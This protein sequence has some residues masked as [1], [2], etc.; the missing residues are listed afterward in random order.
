MK[1]HATLT[2]SLL[3][4]LTLAACGGGGGSDLATPSTTTN[5]T[6]PTAP[7]APV[8]PTPPANSETLPSLINPQSGSTAAVG[9]GVEGIWVDET[10]TIK[11]TVFI[12]SSGNFTYLYLIATTV[13][14]ELF[15]SI[16][17][18]TSNWTMTPGTEFASTFTASPTTGGSGTFVPKQLFTGSYAANGGST[19]ISL[20]YD[21]ANALAV[22]QASVVG[23]WA[24]QGSS[25]TVAN[26]GTVSGTLSYC[27]VT[28]TLVLNTP[29]SNKNLY[30]MTVTLSPA[31][32]SMCSLTSATTYSGNAALVFLPTQVANYYTRTLMYALHSGNTGVA[33]GQLSKQ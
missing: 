31:A 29:N 5:A 23:T 8:A 26:D 24:Q 16:T 14:N 21:A 10:G 20:A 30:T 2:L 3:A 13:M 28:G 15:A 9:N 27:P 18:N 4:S 22:T 32:G 33:Y 6:A 17:T 12:D 7:S 25:M 1:K 11:H 19:S